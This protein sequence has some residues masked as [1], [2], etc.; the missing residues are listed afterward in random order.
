[1]RMGFWLILVFG[2]VV[3]QGGIGHVTALAAGDD[4]TIRTF[5]GGDTT[6]PTTP[7]L[8]SVIPVTQTQISVVWSASVDDVFLVGYRLFRNGVQIATTTQT[9]FNDVGLAPSTLYEYTVDAYD[10]FS[11]ISSS[12][13]PVATTTLAAPGAPAPTSSNP[14][15]STEA[16]RVTPQLDSLVVTPDLRSA[17]FSWQTN[18][19]SRYTLVWGRTTSYELGSISTNVFKQLH[20]TTLENLEPGTRYFYQLTSIDSRDVA[21][22]LKVGEFTT[23]ATFAATTLP[24]VRNVEIAVSGGDVLLQWSNPTLLD[25]AVV[26]VVRSH[27]FYPLG[28][29]DGALVYEG[30]GRSVM[31]LGALSVR[32]PQYY[33]IFIVAKDGAV[34]SGAVAVAYGASRS[35]IPPIVTE[36]VPSKEPVVESG[37]VRILRAESVFIRQGSQT[38]GLATP[39]VLDAENPY[40]L[41]IPLTAVAP[42]L[43]SIIGTIEDPTDQRIETSYLLKLNQSGDAY[44]A[45]IAPPRVMGNSRI[46]IEV[47]DLTQASV[48]RISTSLTFV[49]ADAPTR[50]FPDVLITY[51]RNYVFTLTLISIALL[52]YLVILRR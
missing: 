25:G 39:V 6:P 49:S 19:H 22:V 36:S 52:F 41:I 51:G 29:T 4:I 10:S 46:T 43:K 23:L 8:T 18:I 13:L 24:N 47:F 3:L 38:Y 7:P 17:V 48:R 31:D 50:V 21:K 35:S 30:V 37:D 26:R 5:V 9:S 28:L 44:E 40:T 12:S 42:H 16:T 2:G 33:S 34:S 11:N 15:H 45:V 32:S 14:T 27:I 20:Q 1:M